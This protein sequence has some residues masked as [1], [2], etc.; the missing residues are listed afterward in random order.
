MHVCLSWALRYN[1]PILYSIIATLQM[2]IEHAEL[3]KKEGNALF[4]EL[5]DTEALEKYTEALNVC[6][7]IAF[8]ARHRSV[9]F[10]NRAA[11]HLREK[12]YANAVED[13]SAALELDA[14]YVKAL[15]RRCNAYEALDDLERALSDAQEVV[16]LDP[17]VKAAHETVRRL[18]PV[19]EERREK[20][21]DEMM[22]K[23]KDLGNMVLGKFG[24]SL[25]SFK[26]EKDPNTGGYSINFKG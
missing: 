18:L 17:Q 19:V 25:D 4:A 26:A 14:T 13:C 21:K 22:G 7:V 20:L 2:S 16:K 10:A 5:K 6:P 11:V 15:L 3:L 1:G 12:R 23:L 8:A 9:F 24:M